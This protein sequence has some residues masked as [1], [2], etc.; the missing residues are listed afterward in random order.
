[1]PFD[2]RINVDG[3]NWEAL[4][5]GEGRRFERRI[6][7]LQGA[8]NQAKL[9]AGVPTLHLDDPLPAHPDM[10]GKRRLVETAQPAAL[11]YQCAYVS[12]RNDADHGK[13]H[14]PLR[15]NIKRELHGLKMLPNADILECRR[16]VTFSEET[17]A[18]R[19]LAHQSVRRSSLHFAKNTA[20]M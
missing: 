11:A 4:G 8:K 14:T 18:H 9:C 6:K 7:L 10:P 19:A 13:S 3:R 5:F 2:D 15:P 16:A 12:G 1:M 17:A 20:S